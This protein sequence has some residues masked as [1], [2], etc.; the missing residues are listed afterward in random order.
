MNRGG[1]GGVTSYGLSCQ[2]K[3]NGHPRSQDD[4]G[5]LASCNYS[6]CSPVLLCNHCYQRLDI[7][8]AGLVRRCAF[9]CAM[10]V[11]R[12]LINGRDICLRHDHRYI[13][14]Y[15]FVMKRRANLTRF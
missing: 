11:F 8:I 5:Q 3:L 15:S 2:R 6:N 1:G 14:D 7:E 4:I 9:W 10:I 12:S 13:G